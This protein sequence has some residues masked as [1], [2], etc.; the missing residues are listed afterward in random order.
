MYISR[1]A[2]YTP[3]MPYTYPHNHPEC[4]PCKCT[5]ILVQSRR[6]K[7][8]VN[9][10]GALGR[11][12]E[13]AQ[14]QQYKNVNWVRL[15]RPTIGSPEARAARPCW[16]LLPYVMYDLTNSIKNLSSELGFW[17][18]RGKGWA[19][20]EKQL[21]ELDVHTHIIRIVSGY[22]DRKRT[23][24]ATT[25]NKHNLT[26]NCLEMSKSLQCRWRQPLQQIS[27]ACVK[28]PLTSSLQVAM[29]LHVP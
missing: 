16:A 13:T 5:R 4:T 9:V 17:W 14:N 20:N 2:T 25:I 22:C 28:W 10:A 21:R 7:I 18:Y 6:Q 24:H 19:I 27:R 12:S 11:I 23:R 1:E 3:H 8:P 26:E 15:C 29:Q